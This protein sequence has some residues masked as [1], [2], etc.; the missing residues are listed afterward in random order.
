MRG[1]GIRSGM[2]A[3]VLGLAAGLLVTPSAQAVPQQGGKSVRLTAA[4]IE[5]LSRR[6]EPRIDGTPGQVAAQ[7]GP[8]A[9][10]P[11]L[12]GTKPSVTA[13]PGEHTDSSSSSVTP[14]FQRTGRWE[15]ARGF[16]ESLALGGTKDWVGVFSGGTV[17]RYDAQGRQVWSRGATSLYKDWQVTPGNWF[18]PYPYL[19][20]LYAGYNPY[21]MSAI[22]K[23]P[24]L[25]GDFDGDGVQDIAV[26]YAVGDWP[27]RPFSSPGSKVDYGTF[28][29]VLDGRS[30]KTAWSKLVPGYVGTMLFQDGKLIVANTVGPDWGGDPVPE[31]GDSRS[32]L[33]AYSFGHAG[34]GKLTGTADWTYSTHAPWAYWGDLTSMGSGRIAASWSDTPMDL[35]SPRPA[36]GNVLVLE[37][38]DG[39][40]MAHTKTPGYPRMLVKDP[41]AD[42]V[43]VVEQNDP[44]D[45]VRWDLTAIDAHSGERAVLASREGTVPEAFHVLPN[46]KDGRPRFAV[47]EL[48]ID[49]DMSDGQSTISGWDAQGHTLWSY[50]TASTI[51][52]PNAPTM[53]LASDAKGSEVFA[54]LS[55][56]TTATA[57][58]PAGPEHTQLIG[59]N[60][61][62]GQLDWRKDGAVSGDT[63]T[64]YQGGLLT[65]GYDDTAYTVNSHSGASH[66]IPLAGDPY[67]A[68]ATDVNRDG[69][70]DLVVAGQSRGVF[71]VDGR[72]LKKAAPTVLWRATV[73]SS[74][75]ALR[76]LP[77]PG[78]DAT[79]DLVVAA[80]DH[81]FALLDTH[82]G[83]VRANVHT[84]GYAASLTVV[85]AGRGG[86]EIV[87]PGSSLTAYSGQGKMLWTYRPKGTAGKSLVFSSVTT[88][89]AGHLF[90]EYG[91][92]HHGVGLPT[93]ATDPAPTAVSLDA[94]TGIPNWT[95]TPTGSDAVAIV[96][97]NPALADPNIPGANGHGVAFAYTG[98]F[99]NYR[100]LVQILD[101]R[102]GAVIKNY[103][104]PG[105]SQGFVAS[106]KTGLVE[107]REFNDFVYPANGGEPYDV[108]TFFGFHS[109]VFARSVGGTE[110]F[111]GAY[112]NLW[113]Y[114]T[115]FADNDGF[116][117]ESAT[118][119]ALGAS[120]VKTAALGDGPGDDLIGLA[121]DWR[122]LNIAAQSIGDA[123]NDIDYFPHGLTTYKLSED[124]P[125]RI[126]TPPNGDTSAAAPQTAAK[127]GQFNGDR[128]HSASP[129]KDLDMPIGT[130]SVPIEIQSKTPAA[131][132]LSAGQ[133]N[134]QEVAPGYTPQQIQARLGLKGDGTG[135]TI[136]I[137][138]AYHYPTAKADLN[139]FA[140]HFNLPQTC[141]T[142]GTG[143]DCFDFQQVYADGTQ[144]DV[145]TGWNE[146]AALDIEWAHSAAPHAKI[147]LVEAKDPTMAALSRAQDAAAAL[148]PAAV[149]NSWGAGEFSEEAFYDGH[150]KLADS[151]CVQST[152]DFGYPGSYSATNPYALAIGGTNLRLDADGNTI[153]E[154]AWR[155]TGGGL[156]YFEPRPAYQ[157]GV[158]PSPLR[159][160]PD[161]SFVADPATGVPVYLTMT[162]GG[163]SHSMWFKVGGTSLSAPI[164]GAIIASADQLRATAGK[165]HLASDG[166]DGDTAHTDVYA[167]GSSY[168]RDITAGSNG[169]CGAECT[170]GPGYDT[171]TG[172]GSPT[173]GLDGALAAMK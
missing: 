120:Q 16:A 38:S 66:A 118:D 100:H 53:E 15:T 94:A 161:V 139:H 164:W 107:M 4:A 7:E 134:A 169:R 20:S 52:G 25:T 58:T 147:V 155:S 133:D 150:C 121:L 171:V 23:Q 160:T 167:L 50:T 68:V 165:P 146:E 47:A 141:D 19:P 60:A 113:S 173:A 74:V 30:G 69:S 56:P 77:N 132:R 137:V 71:A 82:S 124:E 46:A 149:S 63:L 21:Q 159:A 104:S 88:D 98:D 90:F 138:D 27:F 152:G 144:P 163:A 151:V 112:Q 36:D 48:G 45:E 125:T 43:L 9:A 1:K 115:P 111:V 127:A 72:T 3:A 136:A 109:A 39:S 84:G 12:P 129:L 116:L 33:T 11:V 123:V 145:E 41:G 110:A 135:Q 172:L 140:A 73:D 128:M 117:R 142:A 106:K 59:L 31:Q 157:D 170:A 6:Y 96:P 99:R 80:T 81:G 51:G 114:D 40:V 78:K 18:Q 86:S 79:G 101:A 42:R 148:H 76:L 35:G 162:Y 34:D 22:G 54:S 8:A 32:N 156:S 119:F 70:K 131:K 75:H 130:A 95:E 65:V 154:T 166:P 14:G 13:G 85:G 105:T 153:D 62:S 64:Q 28:V 103:D 17:A 168:L 37:T 26:A 89:G 10:A 24:Y 67:T 29:T 126:P 92:T 143:E 122:A 108:P 87:V 55:D 83:E 97:T 93:Q 44:F 158:Q 102:S 91:G 61:A 5:R 57:A 49:A 2:V